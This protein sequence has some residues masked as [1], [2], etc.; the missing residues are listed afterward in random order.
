MIYNTSAMDDYFSMETMGETNE[1]SLKLEFDDVVDTQALS[2]V[3]EGLNQVLRETARVFG[4]DEHAVKVL[5]QREEPGGGVCW[6]I[7]LEIDESM[8]S[9]IET[10]VNE[11]TPQFQSLP[12]KIDPVRVFVLCFMGLSILT[13]NQYFP[14]LNERQPVISPNHFYGQLV[15][16]LNRELAGRLPES[17]VEVS[18]VGQ[19]IRNYIENASGISILGNFAK[20]LIKLAHP[21]TATMRL[22]SAVQLGCGRDAGRFVLFSPAVLKLIPSSLPEVEKK[23]YEPEYVK[24]VQVEIVEMTK[25]DKRGTILKGRILPC[26]SYPIERLVASSEELQKELLRHFPASVTADIMILRKSG[27]LGNPIPDQYIITKI[28][29]SPAA[30]AI[31]L[32]SGGT[33]CP[34]DTASP[35]SE[36]AES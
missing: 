1:V 36:P 22:F 11:R 23:P 28:Y 20:G 21:G 31:V 14:Y 5:L 16:L 33:D 7:K 26:G 10:K 17:T 15:L 2:T 32:S 6:G 29:D 3:A 34:Q 12:V 18:L 30:S 19:C 25:D 9:R 35:A 8:R 4:G 27:E 24:G 13:I